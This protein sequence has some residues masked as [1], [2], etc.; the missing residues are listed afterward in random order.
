MILV[1][2]LLTQMVSN[3][4]SKEWLG[5]VRRLDFSEKRC[6][7]S[8]QATHVFV[9]LAVVEFFSYGNLGKADLAISSDAL[10]AKSGS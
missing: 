8:R 10:I 1:F 3:L 7:R 2:S 4:I 9:C 5:K 6:N